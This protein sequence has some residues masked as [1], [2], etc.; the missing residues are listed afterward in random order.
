MFAKF[1][2]WIWNEYQTNGAKPTHFD[3]PEKNN[4]GSLILPF[5]KENL[6]TT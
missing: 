3:L 5:I 2:T 6:E 4:W 1:Y